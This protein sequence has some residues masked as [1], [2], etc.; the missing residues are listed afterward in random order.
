MY[1][2]ADSE[3]HATTL[4]PVSKFLL[5]QYLEEIFMVELYHATYPSEEIY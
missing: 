3:F 1:F 4:L 2:S 5:Y